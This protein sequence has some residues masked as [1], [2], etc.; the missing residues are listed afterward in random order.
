MAAGRQ[1]YGEANMTEETRKRRA[2]SINEALIAIMKT[3]I[4]AEVGKMIEGGASVEQVNESLPHI[5]F[6][7]DAWREETLQRLMS[8]FDDLERPRPTD[9]VVS[10]RPN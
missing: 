9:D 10:L 8:E 6:F 7:H 4:K 3:R 2:Y 5:V 1:E